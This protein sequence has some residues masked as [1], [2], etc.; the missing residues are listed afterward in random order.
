ML[1]LHYF[2]SWAESITSILFF[3]K[4]TSKLS[5]KIN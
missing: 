1:L 3:S 5:E 4:K 2:V